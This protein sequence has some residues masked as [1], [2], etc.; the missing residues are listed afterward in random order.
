MLKT[1]SLKNF[2][3]Y[4]D[5]SIE[6]G[7]FTVITGNNGFG[8]SNLIRALQWN[9]D[10][11]GTWSSIPRKAKDTKEVSVNIVQD[12]GTIL[13]RFRTCDDKVNA[14]II[15]SPDGKELT[16]DKV[17]RG[18]LPP[19]VTTTVTTAPK[20]GKQDTLAVQFASQHDAPFLLTS[21]ASELET[22]FSQLVGL[23]ALQKASSEVATGL[24]KAQND[25]NYQLPRRDAFLTATG[26]FT[27]IAEAEE[28]V[29]KLKKVSDRQE[30]ISTRLL[31][32]QTLYI[33]YVSLCTVAG[34]IDQDIASLDKI[35]SKCQQLLVQMDSI[36]TNR[37]AA[38][39]MREIAAIDTNRDKLATLTS[40]MGQI[41]EKMERIEEKRKGS[42]VILE[43]QKQ[44][45]KLDNDL[46]QLVTQQGK[47]KDREMAVLGE[48]SGFDSCP[49]CGSKL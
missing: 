38:V 36:E 21:S 27:A 2:R 15:T 47:L 28:I 41:I 30:A 23:E 35:T 8:K 43:K 29:A 13:T 37:K 3:S 48:L 7:M 39:V 14:Y 49:V 22:Q 6:L 25:Y 1:L 31:Q 24:R 9:I 10:N 32:A 20:G 42:M 34:N 19:A 44:L 26:R 33:E 5:T 11:T 46:I 17:G 18:D 16:L 40:D 4:K 45:G 12:T